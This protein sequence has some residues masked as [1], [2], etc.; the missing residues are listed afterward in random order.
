MVGKLITGWNIPFSE[1]W[2]MYLDAHRNPWTR[3][4][5]YFAS[6]LGLISTIIAVN[7]GEFIYMA[8]GIAA[9]YAIAILSHKFIEGNK[10]LI[11]VNPF[12]GMFADVRMCWLAA[13]GGLRGEYK[14]LG[15]G[16]PSPLERP[17]PNAR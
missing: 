13:S 16:E 5:H 15:L 12:F 4:A 1:F 8:L 6:V 10:P 17:A 14:R 3:G 11:R 7:R 2:R 9:S